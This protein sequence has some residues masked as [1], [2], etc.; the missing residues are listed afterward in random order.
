MTAG[1]D[2]S[3]VR[4]LLLGYETA[5]S[6]RD[7]TRVDRELGDLIADD[8]VEIGASGRRWTAGEVRQLLAAEKLPPVEIDD[9]AA[10]AIRP[11]VVL[12]T[13]RIA[14]S[15]PS[16][17]SSVWVRGEGGWTIRFHQGTPGPA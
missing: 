11:D 1:A 8:F 9:F 10:T 4:D 2:L 5:L 17:R 15:R 16:Q 12:V 13:Y 7:G 14:G 3:E 6:S